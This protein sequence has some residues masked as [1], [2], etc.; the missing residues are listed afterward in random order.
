MDNA[1][2][3]FGS[4]GNRAHEGTERKRRM[5]KASISKLTSNN[6]PGFEQAPACTMGQNG[7]AEQV[8]LPGSPLGSST[9]RGTGCTGVCR[10]VPLPLGAVWLVWVLCASEIICHPFRAVR[11]PAWPPL[12]GWVYLDTV[13][14]TASPIW[15]DKVYKYFSFVFFFFFPPL[16]SSLPSP[17]PLRAYNISS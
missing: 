17:S 15:P 3:S 7:G 2:I 6:L 13:Q 1:H 12:R 16:P 9:L 11:S 14:H 5:I 10:S 8:H 4:L